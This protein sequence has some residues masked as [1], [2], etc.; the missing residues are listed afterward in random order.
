MNLCVLLLSIIVAL[1]NV[2]TAR[3]K[4]CVATDENRYLCTDD[5]AKANA[6]RKQFSTLNFEMSDMGVQQTVA[7]TQA[8]V[9]KVNEVL[10][11]MED[12]FIKEV[13]AKPEYTSVRDKWYVIKRSA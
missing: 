4:I 11:K 2:I 6:Y 3:G 1:V 8:E 13:Y 7:G 10:K 9:D 12:Y 5:A